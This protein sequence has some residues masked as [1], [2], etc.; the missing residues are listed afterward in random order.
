MEWIEYDPQWLVDAAQSELKQYPWLPDAFKRCTKA[1]KKS[2]YYIYFIDPTAANSKNSKWKF[3]Q[4]ITLF[5][6]IH[7][8]I[9]IDIVKDNTI[10]GIEF[11]SQ[12]F[13]S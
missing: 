1:Y 4:C 3:Q 12:L 8:D 11:Y 5:D 2:A 7:G 13:E 9:E 6:T 10:G